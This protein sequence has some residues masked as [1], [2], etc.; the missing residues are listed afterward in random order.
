[1]LKQFTDRYGDDIYIDPSS[2]T[3]LF[4]DYVV[5]VDPPRIVHGT[6]LMLGSEHLFVKEV[7]GKVVEEL[8]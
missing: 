7:A 6:T 8:M 1:M 5:L 2:V 4:T 3:A